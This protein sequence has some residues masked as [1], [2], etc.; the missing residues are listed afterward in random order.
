MNNRLRK[1]I[2]SSEDRDYL[3][4][5]LEDILHDNHCLD[6]IDEIQNSL[7]RYIDTTTSGPFNLEEAKKGKPICTRDGREARIICWDRDSAR[8]PIVA[9]IRLSKELGGKEQVVTYTSD[10][11]YY[12]SKEESKDDLIML[13][14]ELTL[15]IARDRNGSLFIYNEKPEKSNGY[16]YNTGRSQ[17]VVGSSTILPEVK[18]EDEEPYKCRL[19]LYK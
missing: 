16:W 1:I 13:S 5:R 17:L 12:D 3:L 7:C 2:M 19:I 18:W 4:D 6:C 11:Y 10:G 15:W 8:Q 9:L 14:Q